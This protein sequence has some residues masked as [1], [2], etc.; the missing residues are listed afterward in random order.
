MGKPCL[1]LNLLEGRLVVCRLEPSAPVPGWAL[2]KGPLCSVTRTPDELSVVCGESAVPVGSRCDKGWRALQVKGPLAFS[3][4]G[5]LD[6]LADPLA[7][8]EV[9]LFAV[10]TFDTDYVLVRETQ[11]EEAMA[12]LRDAGHTIDAA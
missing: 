3:L 4:T 8:A 5:I 7:R 10:S 6:A 1:N 12:A 9:S 2:S 11:L